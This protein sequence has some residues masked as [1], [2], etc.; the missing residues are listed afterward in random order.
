MVSV[1]VVRACDV[2]RGR[3]VSRLSPCFLCPP[4]CPCTFLGVVLEGPVA[5]GRFQNVVLTWVLGCVVGVPIAIQVGCARWVSDL[6]LW[7]R[8]PRLYRVWHP[9]RKLLVWFCCLLTSQS[10]SLWRL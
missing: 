7:Q 10:R 3:F 8:C 9:S 1:G 2:V 6:A 4:P 5:C